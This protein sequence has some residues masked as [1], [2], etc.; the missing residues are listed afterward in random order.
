MQIVSCS[1]V[2]PVEIPK[3]YTLFLECT[4]YAFHDDFGNV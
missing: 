4:N 2:E 3:L 1:Q